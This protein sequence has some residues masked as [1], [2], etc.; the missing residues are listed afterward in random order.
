[1]LTSRVKKRIELPHEEGQWIDVRMPSVNMMTGVREAADNVALTIA[2]LEKCIV[3][4]S[5][6]EEDGTAIPVT[7]ENVGDLDIETVRVVEA[8]LFA[9]SEAEQKNG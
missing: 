5:Y 1:M 3:A 7:P 8:V 9:R 6:T 2:V 4:W